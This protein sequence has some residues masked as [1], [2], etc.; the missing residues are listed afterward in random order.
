MSTRELVRHTSEELKKMKSRTDWARITRETESDI[1][2]DLI[3]PED[4]EATAAEFSAAMTKK[5]TGRPVSVTHKMP[6]SIR[7]SDDVVEFFKATGKGW[8]TRINEA[9]REYV[10]THRSA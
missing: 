3:Q 9:L 1:E 2:P 7:L 10:R 4:K 8:Q 5:I 6:L